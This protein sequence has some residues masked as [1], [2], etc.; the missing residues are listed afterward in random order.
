ME[1]FPVCQVRYRLLQLRDPRLHTDPTPIIISHF[2]TKKPPTRKASGV[3][4]KNLA[5]SYLRV[6][7]PTL[8]SALS[9]F[10]T[11][12]G[13]DS[14]GTRPLWPP[15]K[16]VNNLE[17]VILGA[18][19]LPSRTR[20]RKP[21]GCYMVKPHGQLVLVSCTHYCASTPSLSTS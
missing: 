2:P 20:V 5:V 8:S 21:L 11:E 3:S 1:Y 9:V 10:T 6:G 16:P 17:V 4:N 13:M 14:G 19:M 18:G 15:G 12:F 7:N